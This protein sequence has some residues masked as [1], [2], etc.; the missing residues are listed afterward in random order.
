MRIL[1]AAK[2]K[3]DDRYNRIDI[4]SSGGFLL[5]MTSLE[6]F[7]FYVIFKTWCLFNF[8]LHFVSK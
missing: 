8:K 5:M 7:H 3:A 6:V 2:G 1:G 4:L